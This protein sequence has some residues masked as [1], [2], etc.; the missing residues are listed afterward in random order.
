MKLSSAYILEQ[1][2][3]EYRV[4]GKNEITGEDGY[5]RPFFCLDS[6]RENTGTVVQKWKGHVRILSSGT[7]FREIQWRSDVLWISCGKGECR[8]S[9]PYIQITGGNES[10]NPEEELYLEARVLNSVQRI[11][12]RCE[13]WE[14]MLREEVLRGRNLQR[15]LQLSAEFLGN[16][17]LVMGL[18]F[19][20]LGEAG[21]EVIPE[22]S[23]LF[24]SD[25]IDMEYMNALMQSAEYQKMQE[26]RDV[27]L[28][29]A[30]ISRVRSLNRNLFPEGKS[31]CR[32][33]MHEWN[34][35]FT[36]GDRCLLNVLAD[37]L[38]LLLMHSDTL[39]GE[40]VIAGIF[41][42]ILK[43]RAADYMEMSRRLSVN[44]WSSQHTYL[45]LILQLTYLNQKN[46][47]TNAICHYIKRKFPQSASFVFEGEIVT[48]FNMTLL[49]KDTEEVGSVLTY[50]IRDSYLKAGYSRCVKGHMYIRRQF[51]QARTALDVGSRNRP[52]VW[53]HHFDQVALTYIMEQV[54]RRLPASMI[55]HE[56]LLKLKETDEENHSEYMKT[57]RAYLDENLNA[58]RA[59]EELF[60][61]R[62][63]FLYRLE[64]IKEI[65][66]SDLDDPDE[67]FY[68][69]FS[70]RLL[71]QEEEEIP[72]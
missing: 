70:F 36:E 64:K 38:E 14:N 66:Q 51:I 8:V 42:T 4:R 22:K 45:C 25:G 3:E 46:L 20:L 67:I 28:F 47:S 61:H 6:E 11:F 24:H 5:L 58:T 15:I 63:T 12:D 13:A 10:K 59:A 2:K 60:I 21:T 35:T 40:D 71:E 37:Y 69:N 56:N 68:L 49:H 33:V 55:C 48:F 23:R 53:I 44:G 30:Y 50:F 31:V 7:D 57:L 32:V 16:P 18:D 41:Q 43:D 29:P 19:T 39:S 17:L 34:R 54:T 72:V 62:S 1:L 9:V 26:S 65:L 52:Y 27:V